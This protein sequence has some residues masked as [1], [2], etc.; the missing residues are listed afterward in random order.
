MKKF[1]KSVKKAMPCSEIGVEGNVRRRN[2]LH[3]FLAQEIPP[4]FLC[5][6]STS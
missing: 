6:K 1:M 4:N 5:K 3:F 2:L